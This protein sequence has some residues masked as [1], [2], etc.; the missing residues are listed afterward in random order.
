MS[1]S[2][3]ETRYWPRVGLYV[4]KKSAAQFIERMGGTG[5]TLDEDLEEFVSPGIPDPKL[6]A[7]E[8]E[9]L[10]E[11]PYESHDLSSENKAILTLM[12]YESNKKKFIMEKKAEGLSLDEAKEAYKSG[13]DA[14]VFTSL[15]EETQARVMKQIEEKASEE[16]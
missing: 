16:E 15:P 11:A 13:L 12:Q 2:A 3:E 1:S 10:F 5:H 14:L 9:T 4:T 6:L 7:D 8:V